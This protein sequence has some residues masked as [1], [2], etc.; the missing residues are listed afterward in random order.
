MPWEA[1]FQRV[2][3]SRP[4]PGARGTFLL[5]I[6]PFHGRPIVLRD[7]TAV[8]RG[9]LVAEVHFWNARIAARK[10]QGTR[11]LT[12]SMIR[13]LRADFRA[14]AVALAPL[15]L[16]RRPQ[17][18]YGVTPLAEGAARLGFEIRALPQGWTRRALSWWQGRVLS[19]VFRPAG[20]SRAAH[21]S[22]E[23]WL[24]FQDLQKRFHKGA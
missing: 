9:A 14:L 10:T 17:A 20:E 6:H 4:V 19:R 3:H 8:G 16:E 24:S 2:T 1:L 12:W 7:G 23:V 18:V 13:D 15:P 22:Q 5:S 21:D 11:D